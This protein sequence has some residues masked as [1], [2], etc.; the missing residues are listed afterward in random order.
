M[1]KTQ[2][3]AFP[4]FIYFW[5]P[6]PDLV[7]HTAFNTLYIVV[8]TFVSRKKMKIFCLLNLS[9]M[10]PAEGPGSEEKIREKSALD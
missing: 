9:G 10:S 7:D 2:L 4:Y 3:R 6:L 5:P 8:C 1:K